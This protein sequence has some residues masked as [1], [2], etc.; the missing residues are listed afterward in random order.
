MSKLP[1][2][3]CVGLALFNA[4]GKVFVGER[5]DSPGAWQMPQGGVDPGEDIHTAAFRELQEEV[6]TQTADILEISEEL[7]RYEFPPDLPNAYLRENFRGQ[8]QTWVALRY[9]GKDADINL[10]AHDPAEFQAWQWVDLE[11]IVDLIVPFKRDLYRQVI[12][13]FRKFATAL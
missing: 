3:P 13:K 12:I 8:E 6:G 10:N 1:Y 9:T 7:L 11:Q 5:I 2:R 4:E